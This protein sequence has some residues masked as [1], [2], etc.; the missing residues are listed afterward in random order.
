MER[1]EEKSRIVVGKGREGER[2]GRKRK[3]KKKMCRAVLENG[4]GR[5]RRGE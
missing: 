2:R 1:K 3:G 4:K 5:K